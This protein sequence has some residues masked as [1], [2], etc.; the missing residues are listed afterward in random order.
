MDLVITIFYTLL[1]LAVLISFHEFGHFYVAR[2]CGVKVIRFSVGFG[3]K[4]LRWKDKQGTEFVLSALPLGG[5]VKMVDEREGSVSSEDLP[6]AFTQKTVWQRMAIVIA[7]PAANFILAILIYWVLLLN[8]TT[9]IVPIVGSVIPESIAEKAGI[10]PGY[11]VVAI[12]GKETPT[13]Q[14]LHSTLLDR[15][16]ESGDIS[17]TVRLSESSEPLNYSGSLDNWMSGYSDLDPLKGIGLILY[18]PKTPPIIDMVIPKSPAE[19]S[20]LSSGDLLLSADNQ[21]LLDWSSWVEYVR[22]RPS[23]SIDLQVKR[24]NTSFNTTIIPESILSGSGAY[25]GKV[26]MS[27]K[28]PV[29]P[30]KMIQEFSYDPVEALIESV[31]KTWDT[32]AMILGSVKKMLV[33][34]ISLKHLNGPITIGKVAG[35]SAEYGISAYLGFIAL[36]SISLGIM[37]L[38]PVPVLDGG[39]LM[40][41]VIEAVKGSP[42]SDRLQLL[43]FKLGIFLVVGLMSIALYNDILS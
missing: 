35:K 31:Y 13:V 8:G 1:A 18:M 23:K 19:K 20:G 9:G 30:K 34:D 41:F 7:G 32:S 39:H 3:S 5:Y 42:L 10:K 29:W 28:A 25:I 36:L 37:N 38:L 24:E 21:P 6:S 17:F 22:E 26:G 33:G 11:Q 2:A 40:Y 12:D 16:G 43:G 15:I 14:K 27:V 4:L